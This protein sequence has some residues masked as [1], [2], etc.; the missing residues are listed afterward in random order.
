LDDFASLQQV[1]R[2]ARRNLTRPVWDY[3]TGGSESETTLRRN[4]L[5]FDCLALRPAVLNDVSAVDCSTSFLGRPMTMPVMLAPIGSL[6]L[7]H[8]DG[9][10][11]VAKAAEEAGVISFTSSVTVPG[12]EAVGAATSYPKAFQL[13][14]RGDDAWVDNEVAAARDAGFEFFCLTVDT[15]LYSRRE[16]DIVSRWVP[17]AR[18]HSLEGMPWQAALSWDCVRR[19]KDRHDIPLILKGI[20]TAEDAELALAHGVEAVYVSNH[21]GRQLDHGRGTADVLPEIA[22]VVGGRCP[23]IVDGGVLR[24]TDVLKALALGADAVAIGRLQGFGLA[25][26]GREGVVRTLALLRSEIEISMALLGVRSL[27]E[28]DAE[29]VCEDEPVAAP[30][31]TSPYP[32]IEFEE[33]EYDR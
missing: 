3:L 24:G 12:R 16:R 11:G 4:R 1:A 7:L 17:A 30:H 18:R 5:A 22:A 23:V 19:F 2:H 33:L 31:V 10:V 27:D 8:P 29:C 26:G 20:A 6:Q 14:V 15:A 9:A 25:A 21:G 28:I 32:M 13:Y